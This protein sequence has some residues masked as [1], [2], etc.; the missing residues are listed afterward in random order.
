MNLLKIINQLI[1]IGPG[2]HCDPDQDNDGIP[3]GLDNCPLVQNYDQVDEDSDGQGDACD[4]D[5]DGDGIL[6]ENDNCPHNSEIGSTDFRA[7][8]QINLCTEYEY[9]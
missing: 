1:F 4:K 3:N 2:D 8:Q 9:I 7:I 5:D 6:D